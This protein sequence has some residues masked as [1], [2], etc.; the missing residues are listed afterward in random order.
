MARSFSLD[1][2][3]DP[4]DPRS[5]SKIVA[6]IKVAAAWAGKDAEHQVV[7]QAISDWIGA[8]KPKAVEAAAVVAD[9]ANGVNGT[10]PLIT[11]TP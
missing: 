7:A 6:Q 9:S 3:P 4:A 10:S 11:I 2:L 1:L 8:G 5:E